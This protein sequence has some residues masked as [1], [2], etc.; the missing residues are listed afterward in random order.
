MQF[1]ALDSNIGEQ[2]AWVVFLLRLSP[3]L[4][5]NLLNYALGLTKVPLLPYVG[6]SWL[7]NNHLPQPHFFPCIERTSRRC[8]VYS[9]PTSNPDA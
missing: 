3:L 6:A 9:T 8:K 1:A 2:G 5:F 7:G 4:P